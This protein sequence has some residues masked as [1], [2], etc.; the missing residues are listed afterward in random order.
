MKEEGRRK[1]EEGRRKKEESFNCQF[2]MPD[3]QFPMTNYQILGV[4]DRDRSD[5]E[6]PVRNQRNWPEY[7]DGQFDSQSDRVRRTQKDD[8]KSRAAR[9]YIE[10]GY[11]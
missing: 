2:P 4:K 7:L 6:S 3:A 11:F 5:K 9:D 1:K 10:S 8:R